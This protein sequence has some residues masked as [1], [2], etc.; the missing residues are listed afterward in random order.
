MKKRSKQL[1]AAVVLAKQVRRFEKKFRIRGTGALLKTSN[2]QQAKPIL[3]VWSQKRGTFA[4]VSPIDLFMGFVF[5]DVGDEVSLEKESFSPGILSTYSRQSSV[6]AGS[7]SV[8][9]ESF[10]RQSLVQ[11][12]DDILHEDIHGEFSNFPWEIDES[13]T[14]VLADL[15]AEE[16]LSTHCGFKK[17]PGAL[18]EMRNKIRHH[19]ILSK[20]L[21]VF[22]NKVLVFFK[23]VLR[24]GEV[25]R[26][27]HYAR[28]EKMLKGYPTYAKYF[29]EFNQDSF[30]AQVSH[31]LAYFRFYD[32]VVALHEK[33][34]DLLWLLCFLKRA[35]KN[36]V[37]FEQYL[38]S[39]GKRH[40]VC[41]KR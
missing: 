21:L 16:F 24:D 10:A 36:I 14:T 6:Y 26:P 20:E 25:P 3:Y 22:A 29:G 35:P 27:S 12:V 2:E 33:K 5:T 7:D 41:K 19:R 31:D 18:Q 39:F 38:S 4:F 40:K 9:T 17:I 11:Q 37:R 23:R 15:F 13:L 30:E 1:G 34:A 32:R 28:I 8:I